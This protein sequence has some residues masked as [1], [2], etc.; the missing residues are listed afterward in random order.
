MQPAEIMAEVK[1]LPA[2]QQAAVRRE[3]VGLDP[4]RIPAKDVA[5]IWKIVLVT[6]AILGVGALAGGIFLI[7]ED[8]SAEP[9]WPFV[10]LVIGGLVGLIAPS[11]VNE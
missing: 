2:D 4:R 5:G 7:T 9:L 11:P 8:K 10:T 1:N 3:L 6:L